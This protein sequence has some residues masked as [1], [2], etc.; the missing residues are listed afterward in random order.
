MRSSP[1]MLR[2][3]PAQRGQADEGGQEAEG[4]R[5]GQSFSYIKSEKFT[6]TAL[7]GGLRLWIAC[8]RM[9]TS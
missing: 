5:E 1:V 4:V 7:S 9:K 6:L 3:T 2:D 8:A